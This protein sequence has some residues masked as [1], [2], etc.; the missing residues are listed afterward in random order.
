MSAIRQRDQLV[1]LAARHAMPTL[2]YS[3]EFVCTSNTARSVA[4]TSS[5]SSR[6]CHGIVE[7]L[8]DILRQQQR[9]CALHI[10]AIIVAASPPHCVVRLSHGLPPPDG[11]AISE[12]M[13]NLYN[14]KTLMLAEK[15]LTH[16]TRGSNRN[17][18]NQ[19]NLQ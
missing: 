17:Q 6:A 7:H 1:A 13:R 16:K 19:N 2:H 14:E 5:T 10:D 4:T 8:S 9:Q 15:T 12:G 11:T 18:N 3:R